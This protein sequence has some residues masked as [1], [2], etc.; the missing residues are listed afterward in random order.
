VLRG[1]E[2]YPFVGKANTKA[3]LDEIAAKPEAIGYGSLASGP[4]K[5][6]V[7]IKFGPTSVGIV[8]TEDAIRARKYPITRTISW[9]VPRKR[10]R[11]ADAFCRWI[12]SSEG[13][14]VVEASGFEPLLPAERQKALAKFGTSP[15]VMP[16]AFVGH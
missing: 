3:L 13:Q 9:V 14:L 7:A 15:T 1:E 11:N 8:P 16:V 10:D 4:G 5:R 6:A 2:P 12:L